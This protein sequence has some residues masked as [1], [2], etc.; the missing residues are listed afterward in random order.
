MAKTPEGIFTEK[1][2]KY[3]KSLDK[4]WYYKV[5]GGGMFQRS[6]IPDIIGC[7]NGMFFALELKAE[8]G[9]PSE[10]QLYNL[11]KINKAGGYGVLLYPSQFEE[12]KENF[13]YVCKKSKQ[14]IS[15]KN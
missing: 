1:V 13:E 14:K 9:K 15:R 10:L 3:L 7:Y 2:I 5:F 11:D 8:N 4:C 6:G 12:F